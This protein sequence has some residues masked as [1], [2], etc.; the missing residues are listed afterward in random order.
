[1][2]IF[3]GDDL[4][5]VLKAKLPF[6]HN[7]YTTLW[8]NTDQPEFD[9]VEIYVARK[10]QSKPGGLSHYAVKRDCRRNRRGCEDGTCGD[11]NCPDCEEI[12]ELEQHECHVGLGSCVVPF[13]FEGH[14]L[15]IW[16]RIEGPPAATEGEIKK[17]PEILLFAPGRDSISVL[18]EFVRIAYIEV[19]RTRKLDGTFVLYRYDYC[20]RLSPVLFFGVGCL[21]SGC[22]LLI[23][24]D[25]FAVQVCHMKE[26]LSECY[27]QNEGISKTTT[28]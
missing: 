5:E 17:Y 3:V 15:W 14:Q 28:A 4:E 1:M 21:L 24:E 13:D 11:H 8:V 10:L 6:D 20:L 7:A 9:S 23:L 18:Q 12:S 2:S 26:R 27:G 22:L 25:L 19:N 16:K